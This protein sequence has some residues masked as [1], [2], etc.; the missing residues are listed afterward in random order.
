M[1][2][3]FDG[4]VESTN[5]IAQQRTLLR[6]VFREGVVLPLQGEASR[7]QPF[8]RFGVVVVSHGH[9]GRG[10]LAERHDCLRRG[11]CS[12]RKRD[13]LVTNARAERGNLARSGRIRAVGAA[14]SERCSC[15][16]AV[17][18]P[19]RPRGR[20]GRGCRPGAARSR[21]R[22]AALRRSRRRRGTDTTGLR[23]P[24]P[25]T[26]SAPTC[27]KE[28]S[29]ARSWSAMLSSAKARAARTSLNPAVLM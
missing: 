17:R 3:S 19:C 28:S 15:R 6:A 20:S 8:M 14:R 26:S 22:L 5:D 23:R 24:R 9:P 13:R 18:G 2:E 4:V 12:W 7:D 29:V 1:A 16:C 21:L 25:R 10:R 27:R 11:R